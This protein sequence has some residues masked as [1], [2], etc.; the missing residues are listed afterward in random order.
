MRGEY[1][2]SWG[3]MPTSWETFIEKVRR[4]GTQSEETFKSYVKGARYFLEVHGYGPDRSDELVER[5]KRGEVDPYRALDEFVGEMVKRGVAPKS[6]TIWVHGARK[7]LEFNGI[8]LDKERLKSEVVLPKPYT[9]NVDRIPTHEEL[10]RGF[11]LANLDQKALL[12]LL[13]STGMRIGEALKVKVEDLR[14]DE[15][16]PHIVLRPEYCKGRRGRAVLLTREA[17]AILKEYVAVKG[18]SGGDRLFNLTIAGAEEKLR[19]LFFKIGL[20]E[21]SRRFYVVHA[22]CLRKYFRTMC[23]VAGV[24]EAFTHMLLGHKAYL[25]ESYLRANLAMVKAEYAKVEPYLTLGGVAQE[26][27]SERVLRL[28]STLGLTPQEVFNILKSRFNFELRA[29]EGVRGVDAQAAAIESLKL[30]YTIFPQEI[31]EAIKDY[32]VRRRAD[33]GRRFVVVSGEEELLRKL[34]E[35]Y[36]LVKELSGGRFLLRAP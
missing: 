6:I 29:T 34:E 23:A 3:R 26:D 25:D 22:H 36:E 2:I 9:V 4:I 32:V 8:R 10:K 35:G 24:Q 14:L 15:D 12:C 1:D 21:K 16:P 7:F 13:V 27:K 20:K 17:V 5:V 19:R 30:L 18:L 33:G 11:M 31:E 28:I